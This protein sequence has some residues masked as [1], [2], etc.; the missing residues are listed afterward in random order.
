MSRCKTTTHNL[1]GV[2]ALTQALAI[3]QWVVHYLYKVVP[4][5]FYLIKV[6]IASQ[7]ASTTQLVVSLPYSTHL[8][9]Q[10]SQVLYCFYLIGYHELLVFIVLSIQVHV[11]L[12][13]LLATDYISQLPLLGYALLYTSL[14]VGFS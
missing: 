14:R 7:P 9:Q 3:L 5:S 11:S 4:R 6:A 8:Y 13:L 2:V 1:Y 12:L 10:T